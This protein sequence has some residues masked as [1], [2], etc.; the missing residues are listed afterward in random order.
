VSGKKEGAAPDWER[1]EFDYRA[2]VKTLRQIAEEH[3]I[4]HG[5]VNKRA[6]TKGW[7]RDLKAKILAAAEAKVSKSL[8]SA[9]VSAQRLATEHQVVESNA[10]AVANVRIGQRSD[11]Q[12]GRSLVM[13][14]LAELEQQ[15]EHADLF[16]DLGEMLR[17]EDDRGQDKRNDLYHKVIS[18]SGR[19]SNVKAL[20]DALKNLVALE[21]EAWGLDE[22][23]K[24]P[25]DAM[26][27]ADDELERRIEAMNERLGF[28]RA[29]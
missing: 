2:G 3:G 22:K 13:K 16:E 12:R 28:K 18:L 14:L 4:T 15:T 1:I 26:E 7:T 19:V 21:R 20:S 24:P 9:E 8:V 6:K 27:L 10:I 29:G 5:A 11:I 25:A 23:E 17:K